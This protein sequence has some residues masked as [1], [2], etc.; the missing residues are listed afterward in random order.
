MKVAVLISGRG[1][2][3]LSLL[4][5]AAVPGYPAEIVCVIANRPDAGGLNHAAAFGIAAQVVDHRSYADRTAF[6]AALTEA[7]DGAGIDLICLAGFMRVLSGAFVR[8]WENRIVNIHPSLLPLFPGLDTHAR[9]LSAGVKLHGCS[10]HFVNE[11]VDGGAIIGQAAVAVQTGD[12]AESLAA[13]VLQAEHRL[14]PLCLRLLA[15]GRVRLDD[16]QARIDGAPEAGSALF[17]PDLSA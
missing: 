4:E 14:Y 13:R 15:E 1:S 6:E 3:L 2:N 8:R 16:G 11:T 12:N 9:A 10:V 7:L 17:S 5:A